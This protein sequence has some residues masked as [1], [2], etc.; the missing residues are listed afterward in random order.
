MDNNIRTLQGD[1]LARDLRV[2]IVA[3]RF[4]EAIVEHLVRGAVDALIR[5]G[6]SEKQI[7]IIRVPGAYDLPF[8]A[9][10]VAM[11]KR[12][13]AIVALGCVIRGATPHFDY[14]AGQCAS[15]LARAADD[16]GVPIAFG[17]LTTE[18]IEQA[19]E[20]AGTK[21]GNK[22]ADAAMVALEMANLL[23]RI[24]G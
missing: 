23:R 6:A 11:A 20:R 14:V 24:A 19:V 1:L 15:G 21:A 17:V 5:H 3:A 13:D 18:T 4:N 16:S 12:A 2:A 22:G 7:E 9:R 8:V 10:R